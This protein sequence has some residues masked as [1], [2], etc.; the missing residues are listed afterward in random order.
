LPQLVSPREYL[1]QLNTTLRENAYQVGQILSGD[2]LK[3]TGEITTPDNPSDWNFY[4]IQKQGRQFLVSVQ[5]KKYNPYEEP[6]KRFDPTTWFHIDFMPIPKDFAAYPNPASLL[7][8]HEKPDGPRFTFDF[9]VKLK[10]AYQGILPIFGGTS[11]IEFRHLKNKSV[12][13]FL[14]NQEG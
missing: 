14:P 8:I 13:D 2:T 10:G 3:V 6:V 4:F 11:R 1:K 9:E 5:G 7:E 12:E